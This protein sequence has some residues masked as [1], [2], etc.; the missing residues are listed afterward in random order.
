MKLEG[1]SSG[2]TEGQQDR[3]WR[4]EGTGCKLAASANP[5]ARSPFGAAT[6]LVQESQDCQPVGLLFR[7][8]KA[9]VVAGVVVDDVKL[10][11]GAGQDRSS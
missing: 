2:A 6:Y 4:D 5:V 11:G 9:G 8:F 7:F 1:Q 3:G 10:R